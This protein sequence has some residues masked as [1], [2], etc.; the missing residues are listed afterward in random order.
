MPSIS[1]PPLKVFPVSVCKAVSFWLVSEARC[2]RRNASSKN[3]VCLCVRNSELRVASHGSLACFRK[4]RDL[5]SDT[6]S[7]RKFDE[8]VTLILKGNWTTDGLK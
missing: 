3:S 1:P 8:S 6:K 5:I 7:I 4:K 2:C